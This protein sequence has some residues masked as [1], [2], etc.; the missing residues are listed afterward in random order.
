[1]LLALLVFLNII[2]VEAQGDD[3]AR[4]VTDREE[5]NKQSHNRRNW[6]RIHRRLIKDIKHLEGR[7]DMLKEEKE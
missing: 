1:M 5:E 7:T 2:P 3:N 6:N 4:P